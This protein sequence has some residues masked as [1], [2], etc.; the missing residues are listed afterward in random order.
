MTRPDIQMKMSYSGLEL[1]GY[2]MS[3]NKKKVAASYNRKTESFTYTPS[4]DLAPGKH[5]VSLKIEFKGY[6]PK[7]YNWSF[8]VK[9]NAVAAASADDSS[10]KEAL[11][12]INSLR[13]SAGLSPVVLNEKLNLTASTHAKY[14]SVHGVLSHLE[15]PGKK[16]F[17][18]RSLAERASYFGYSSNRIYE[19]IS[20]QSDTSAAKTV[21]DLYDAPYHRIP[22]LDPDLK[23]IGYGRSGSYHVLLF[24]AGESKTAPVPVVSPVGES[25]PA[26][27]NGHESPDPLRI[28]TGISYPIGYPIMAGVYGYGITKV[29]PVEGSL[30]EKSTSKR[31]SLQTNGADK[32]SHLSREVLYLPATPLKAGTVYQMKVVMKAYLSDGSSKLYSKQWTFQ[33]KG[34]GT[35]A[36]KAAK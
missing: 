31:V 10:Q 20:M 7:T 36:A 16:G 26:S 19:D 12:A 23:E 6:T 5:E 1:S 17:T 3:L 34:T 15:T 11:K 29:V 21:S 33:T 8:T 18:G 32:D 35:G 22:F 2:S 13:K 28:H 27:W 25:V 9:P 24:G 14:Q 30:I 4:S